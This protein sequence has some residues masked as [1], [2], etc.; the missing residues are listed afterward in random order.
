MRYISRSRVPGVE[1]DSFITESRQ[2]LANT[3]IPPGTYLGIHPTTQT[4]PLKHHNMSTSTS[5]PTSPKVWLITGC[6]SGFGST[7]ATLALQRGDTVIATARTLTK[8][9]HLSTLGA[10]ILA[11]DVTSPD[12]T[13]SSVIATAIA[14]HGRI[15]ILVNNAGAVLE[16]AIEE[17]S[18]AEAKANFDV[19]VFGTLAVTRA[20]LPYMRAA[21][22]GVIA[23][24]GSVGGWHGSVGCGVY[25]STKWALAGIFDALKAEVKHL[26]IEVTLIEPGYFRTDLLAKGNKVVAEREIEDFKPVMEPLR[27]A[28][29]EYNHNQPGDP[30]KGSQLIVEALTHSGRCEGRTLP[31]RL[32]MG[33]DYVK[34]VEGILEAEKRELDEWRDLSLSTDF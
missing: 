14:Q 19:N 28:F 9:S 21:R 27:R 16:G 22:S 17:T 20:V 7:I 33:S 23:G 6:S 5:T 4:A 1:A 13:I 31:W 8:L 29:E 15:D 12:S 25:C 11:L 18:D 24:L 10:T 26:G 30:V 34:T 3:S 32:G 2:V